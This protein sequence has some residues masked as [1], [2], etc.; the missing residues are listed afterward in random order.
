MRVISWFSRLSDRYVRVRSS[1]P[2]STRYFSTQTKNFAVLLYLFANKNIALSI[3]IKKISL[4]IQRGNGSS[5]ASVLGTIPST[6]QMDEIYN[7]QFC[8]I[9]FNFFYING[10]NYWRIKYSL[11]IVSKYSCLVKFSYSS[12]KFYIE[13]YIWLNNLSNITPH[14]PIVFPSHLQEISTLISRSPSQI[15]ITRWH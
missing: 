5:S 14:T 3:W 10:D 12:V 9:S 2:Y 11:Q 4:A 1:I 6:V 13:K 7:L 15:L 8:K